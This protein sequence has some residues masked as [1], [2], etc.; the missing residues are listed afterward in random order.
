ML[1]CMALSGL[2]FFWWNQSA[3]PSA[4]HWYMRL[5]VIWGM[6][7]YC[8]HLTP[9]ESQPSKFH[10]ATL[11]RCCLPFATCAVPNLVQ[12]ACCMSFPFTLHAAFPLRISWKTPP[13]TAA[14]SNQHYRHYPMV[15]Q[16][17]VNRL[18]S[19][20]QSSQTPW[21]TLP[22]LLSTSGCSQTPLK[23]SNVLPY[24]ARAFSC[25]PESTCSC[26][27]AFRMLRDLTDRIVQF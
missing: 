23:L 6:D 8:C 11:G 14:K 15:H 26:R 21:A 2:H 16:E 7:R 10:L 24:S 17:N 27:G 3:P 20:T 12:V 22:A 25:A 19:N 18:L 5:G 9:T 4:S 1:E 13:W